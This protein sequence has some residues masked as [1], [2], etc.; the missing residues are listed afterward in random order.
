MATVNQRENGKWQAKI[1]KPG[2]P[3]ETRTFIKEKNARRWAKKRESEMEEGIYLSRSASEKT[4][5]KMLLDRWKET[6]LPAKRAKTHFMS[7]IK[8]ISEAKALGRGA[9]A[10]A[11]ISSADAA[12][13]RDELLRDDLSPSSVRKVMFFAGTLVDYGIENM[14]IVLQANPFRLVKRPPEPDHRSRRLVGDEEQR[15]F[16]AA[17]KIKQHI[18]GTALLRVGLETGARL[19]ELLALEWHELDLKRGVMTLRGREVDEK[20]QLKNTDDLRYTP[21]SLAS[22]AAFQTLTRPI[23]GG[24]VFSVWAASDSFSKQ[25]N[26]IVRSA[27]MTDYT[28]HDLR[29]EFASRMA[30][31][32]PMHVLMKLLGHKSPA[33][34]GRYYNQTIDDVAEL[35]KSLYGAAK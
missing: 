1:R 30:P 22:I 4:T 20:R 15:L 7:C 25:M 31:R 34:V 33:M 21:L 16:A 11:T 5:I 2:F 23:T 29:H 3:I 18:Q 13:L 26:R 12:A 24:R 9:R 6:E 17:G 28:F 14:G 10:L 32:V 35:A 27:K 19:G 8:L